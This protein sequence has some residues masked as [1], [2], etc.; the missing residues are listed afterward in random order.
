MGVLALLLATL[1]L[2]GCGPVTLDAEVDYD[3]D[4]G[5]FLIMKVDRDATWENIEFVL[6]HKYTIQLSDGFILG[7]ATP[8]RPGGVLL[9]AANFADGDKYFNPETTKPTHFKI[10]ALVNGKHGEYIEIWD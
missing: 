4:D 7:P 6:N 10:S 5:S 8:A 3:R 2:V 9:Y 1:L